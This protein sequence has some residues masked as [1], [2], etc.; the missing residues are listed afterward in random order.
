MKCQNLLK[1][2]KQPGYEKPVDLLLS[3]KSCFGPQDP[4]IKFEKVEHGASAFCLPLQN[5]GA[6]ESVDGGQ[7]EFSRHF[8]GVRLTTLV[9]I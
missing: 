2:V 3:C 4:K 7:P 9:L 6:I 5:Q 8:S 1:G